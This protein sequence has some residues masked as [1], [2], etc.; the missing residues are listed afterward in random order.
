MYIF[1]QKR[2][3]FF[4]A[5]IF[6][7]CISNIS[8]SQSISRP[9]VSDA[10][11]VNPNEL[12]NVSTTISGSP[13][14]NG[15]D[16]I[17]RL[18]NKSGGFN[19]N[20]IVIAQTQNIGND[21]I[22]SNFSYPTTDG[23]GTIL[24]SDIY[25]LR[26]EQLNENLQSPRSNE[27]SAY[28]YD[29]T[30]LQLNPRVLCEFGELRAIPNNLSEYIWHR[31]TN[32]GGDQIIQGESG[33][34][35]QANIEGD[36]YFTPQLGNCSG[37]IPE[38]RSNL[39]TVFEATETQVPDFTVLIQS[40]ATP[41]CASEQITLTTDLVD[42][43][44]PDFTFQWIKD[45]EIIDGEINPSITISGIDAE[46]EYFL[47]ISDDSQRARQRCS[48]QSMDRIFVD[49]NNPF[50]RFADTQ[51][52]IVP[53]IPGQEEALTV[54]AT[55][56]QPLTIEWF[57]DGIA[58][59]NSNTN[60]INASGIGAYTARITG[61]SC[62]INEDTTE[63]TIQVIDIDNLDITINYNDPNYS[64][65]IE[66]DIGIVIESISTEVNSS[67]LILDPSSFPPQE[68]SWLN[69]D[70][71]IS[72]LAGPIIALNNPS[73]NGNYTAQVT[74]GNN[75]FI[76][77]TLSVKLNPGE[78]LIDAS[79]AVLTEETPVSV[80]SVAVDAGANESLFTYRWFREG[81]NS[82]ETLSTNNILEVTIAGS[83]SVEVTFDDCP[84]VT[85]EPIDII[86]ASLVIP[87]IITPDGFNNRRWELP[88]RFTGQPNINVQIIS[89]S[90]VEVLNQNNYNGTW[91]NQQL[92]ESVYYYIISE[93]NSPLEKGSITIIR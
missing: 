67:M 87:N 39:V 14:I 52:L 35:L 37:F 69:N 70:E 60:Q 4:L 55:G 50:I 31:I 43:N 91:P 20:S 85:L 47:E 23:E 59:P 65:C 2:V 72:D 32:S 89:S 42:V 82:Q 27:F 22:F 3:N 10:C 61:S 62:A 8:F 29:G 38:A 86:A 9:I 25:R 78:L 68:I 6:C 30:L 92:S 36:Y 13:I 24:G 58:I 46:G 81:L 21:I 83:Y 56:E 34:T 18:S 75:T 51:P 76:S 90:G 41:M 1:L 33:N 17:L 93:N 16:F 73:R 74:L 5:L 15:T 11:F 64:D 71:L 53:D 66:D 48:K 19:S 63:N 40:G 88:P 77:N 26:V 28:F 45:D 12:Q 54:L 80:L 49:L 79:E 7:I 57:K 44:N 84:T